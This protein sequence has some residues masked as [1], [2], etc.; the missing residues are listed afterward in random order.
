MSDEE[1]ENLEAIRN[2]EQVK[3]FRELVEASGQGYG[4]FN[5]TIMN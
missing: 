1:I 5:V 2:K 4:N 3:H